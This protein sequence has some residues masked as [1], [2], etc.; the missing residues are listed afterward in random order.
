M[1]IFIS[2]GTGSIGAHLVKELSAQGH[3]VHA[4]VR[5]LEKGKNIEFQN[6]LLFK[7][8]ILNY[9]EIERAMKGCQQV[10]H[11]A[12]YAK[13]WAKNTGDFYKFNVEGTV[14]VLKSAHVNS[15]DKVVVTSTAGVLGP[16]LSGIINEEKIRDID[17][18]NEYEGSKSMAESKIKDF[19]INYG[20]NVVIVSPSRVYGP[21]LFGEP[22]SVTLM[23]DK[24]VN[25][26]WRIYPGT[27]KE[28]GNYVYIEDV[29]VGHMLAMQHGKSG[30]TY[31][32]GGE[33]HDYISFY[34]TL[35]DDKNPYVDSNGIC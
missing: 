25:G 7:G 10:Y 31:I 21:F 26:S 29:V 16:S 22:S 14:N 2:G 19:I 33:N 27:G 1:K 32:L 15:V 13:V 30:N 9:L 34:S 18:F 12:A 28:L 4:L 23:V 3:T 5:S 20:L 11:L 24:F 17:F 8:D 6:V 35:S